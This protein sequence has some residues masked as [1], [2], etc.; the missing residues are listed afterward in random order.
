MS[1]QCGLHHVPHEY[2]WNLGGVSLRVNSLNAAKWTITICC[3]FGH[4][5]NTKW[6]PDQEPS[7]QPSKNSMLFASA[8]LFI[9]SSLNNLGLFDSNSWDYAV[10]IFSA[11]S[12][13]CLHLPDVQNQYSYTQNRC[14]SFQ[15]HKH[16][17]LGPG[18]AIQHLQTTTFKINLL[19]A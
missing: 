5:F 18:W 16:Y 17:L 10:H 14:Q 11:T 19:G 13:L 3:C 7:L 15:L 1:L 9:T 4:L 8:S 12:L 2:L 6:K